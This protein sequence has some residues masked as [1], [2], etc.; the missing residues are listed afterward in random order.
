[1]SAIVALVATV[2]SMAGFIVAREKIFSDERE[3]HKKELAEAHERLALSED[4][5]RLSERRLIA[6]LVW[7]DSIARSHDNELRKLLK[8]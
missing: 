5:T 6:Y 7:S 4:R 2:V 8:K 1:M 3:A